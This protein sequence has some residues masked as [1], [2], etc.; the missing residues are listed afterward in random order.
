MRFEFS[1]IVS[2]GG[3]QQVLVMC[4]TDY[5]RILYNS[6]V[7]CTVLVSTHVSIFLAFCFH[8]VASSPQSTR[9]HNNKTNK[10]AGSSS[11]SSV[12]TRRT[13]WRQDKSNRCCTAVCVHDPWVDDVLEMLQYCSCTHKSSCTST[14]VIINSISIVE[15]YDTRVSPGKKYACKKGVQVSMYTKHPPRA[16]TWK[17]TK[18]KSI[19][20][21][22]TV[23]LLCSAIL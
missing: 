21:Y 7:S 13:T 14:A 9:Y 16:K 18:P 15:P 10:Q 2:A 5:R 22:D 6:R 20:Y 19:I 17:H 1:E 12:H 4:D 8:K 23:L 11:S 3:L